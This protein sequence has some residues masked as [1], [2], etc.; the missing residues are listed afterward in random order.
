M[1]TPQTHPTTTGARPLTPAD[2]DQAVIE[3]ATALDDLTYQ[4]IEKRWGVPAAPDDHLRREV[5]TAAQP[6][7]PVIARY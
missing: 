3:A 5:V 6:L 1:T 2:N 7:K 4:R